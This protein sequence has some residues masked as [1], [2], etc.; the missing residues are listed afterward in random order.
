MLPNLILYS[1]NLK[2]ASLEITYHYSKIYLHEIAF[3][4]GNNV[5]DFRP[6][7]RLNSPSKT[8]Y[9]LPDLQTARLDCVI[10]SM[11]SAHSLINVLLQLSPQTLR[12]IP[13]VM[14]I[15]LSY[16]IFILL[17]IFFISSAP[18]SG[19]G[20]VLDPASVE[21]AYY[22]NRIVSHMQTAAIGGNCR[23]TIRFCNIFSRSRDWF[24]KHA[25]RTDWESG[26]VDED[27]FEP[28]RLLSLNDEMDCRQC[29]VGVETPDLHQYA[30]T[31]IHSLPLDTVDIVEKD[32]TNRNLWS[33]AV[34]SNQLDRGNLASRTVTWQ[35]PTPWGSQH[36]P[37]DAM[38]PESGMLEAQLGPLPVDDYMQI[39]LGE[40]DNIMDD[41]FDLD[42]GF[43]FDS[44]FWDFD[45]GNTTFEST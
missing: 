38:Q 18:G 44:H 10:T 3:H 2:L 32:G 23:L 8:T 34:K 40:A 9:S 20:C 13:T 31:R 28:F 33:T 29:P 26:G 27:L 4:Y 15:R 22:L 39:P 41:P 17:R 25:L 36:V 35:Y 42:L 43:D 12:V 45:M 19:L 30:A 1:S 16:A 7:F 37:L 24:R 11:T 5:E 21:T 6:P 14:Y